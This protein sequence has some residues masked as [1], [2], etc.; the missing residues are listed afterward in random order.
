[1]QKIENLLRFENINLNAYYGLINHFKI[2]V[3]S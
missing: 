1:M 2:I 3:F